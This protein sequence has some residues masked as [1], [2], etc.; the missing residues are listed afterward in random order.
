MAVE[1]LPSGG[2]A[3][4]MA[5]TGSAQTMRATPSQAGL[6]LLSSHPEKRPAPQRTVPF[7][8]AHVI[9]FAGLES[10]KHDC[11]GCVLVPACTRHVAAC[12]LS[13]RRAHTWTARL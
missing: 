11:K 8:V 9:T 3:A 7:I 1:L 6:K 4:A 12:T 2:G 10:S 13:R 5:A